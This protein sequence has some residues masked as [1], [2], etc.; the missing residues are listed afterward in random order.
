MKKVLTILFSAML[1]A[2]CAIG[3][4]ACAENQEPEG[5]VW[6][7][8]AVY[9]RAQELG[10][11]GTHS[12]FFGIGMDHIF[13]NGENPYYFVAE[14]C[15]IER[16]S[17]TLI[18]GKNGGVIPEGVQRIDTLA[19]DGSSKAVNLVIPNSVVALD[20]EAFSWW[21]DLYSVTIGNGVK[22]I[23]SYAFAKTNIKSV[24]AGIGLKTVGD[25]AFENCALY[26]VYYEGSEEQWNEIGIGIGNDWF[27]AVPRYYHWEIA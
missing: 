18:W 9:A 2:A 10:Y 3:V 24:V 12:A 14:N 7:T 22:S 16:A 4:A 25:Y 11:T 23:G 26:Y 19:F 27:T 6:T 13:I 1:C 5:Q 17:G 15:L 21:D 8:E 20:A